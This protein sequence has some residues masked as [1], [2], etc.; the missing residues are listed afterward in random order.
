MSLGQA[1]TVAKLRWIDS[2]SYFQYQIDHQDDQVPGQDT[3]GG[4]YRLYDTLVDLDPHFQPFYEHAALNLSGMLGRHH[5]A[6]S[7]LM[8]GLDTLPHNT[9]LWRNAAAMFKVQF[10]WEEKQPIA[11]DQFLAAWATAE[12]TEDGRVQVWDWKRNMGTRLFKGLEQLPYWLDQLQTT[13]AR[14]P[15][16]DYVEETAR[17]QLAAFGERELNALL[18][19]W[20]LSARPTLGAWL[21]DLTDPGVPLAE[22][23]RLG[24]MP[25]DLRRLADPR[26][27]ARHHG[28]RLPGF[29]PLRVG[30]DG[31][32]TLLADPYGHP[33]RLTGNRV[34]SLGLACRQ[35]EKRLGF[36]QSAITTAAKDKGRWPTTIDEVR[37]WD[38]AI[39]DLPAGGTLRMVDQQ[40]SVDWDKPPLEP[41]QL[42]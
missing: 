33:W 19:L 8:R 37:A 41:W 4:F 20:R 42:R 13:K 18:R 40:I 14:T 30:Q 1:N 17:A 27:V 9:V 38:I 36:V 3:R 12:L 21:A 7:F 29:G 22:Q 24:G 10:Q 26:L 5:H 34:T 23:L 6:L 32:L 15:M 35:Y 39:P 2:F 16:G 28:D 25:P 31:R 11:F